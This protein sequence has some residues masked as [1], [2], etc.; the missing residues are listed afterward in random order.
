VNVP[1]AN[2]VETGA[3]IA[4]NKIADAALNPPKK[5]VPQ[6]SLY[7]VTGSLQLSDYDKAALKKYVGTLK[8][9]S[10]VKCI[11]YSYAGKVSKPKATKLAKSQAN[12]VCNLMKSYKKDLKTSI[13]IYDA[14]KA[15]AAAKGAKWVGVSFR[16]DGTTK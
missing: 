8:K 12:S 14:K 7:S 15:P 10:S 9:G 2:S 1:V 5:I 3:A 16:I 13:V 6:L 11:G 4:A